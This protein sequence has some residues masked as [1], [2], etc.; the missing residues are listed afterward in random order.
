M[1]KGDMPGKLVIKPIDPT[2]LTEEDKITRTLEAVNLIKDKRYGWIKGR[3][4]A[5]SSRQHRYL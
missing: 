2:L 3:I 4:G 5:D 1:D